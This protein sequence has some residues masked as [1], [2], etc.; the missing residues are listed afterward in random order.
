VPG[1]RR[2]PVP[3]PVKRDAVRGKFC[4]F[5]GGPAINVPAV[6]LERVDA[7]RDELPARRR[8]KVV[9]E[10][11]AGFKPPRPPFVLEIPYELLF[12]E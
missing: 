2:A 9:V 5:V 4:R 12:A 3:L 10:D 8:R 6:F 11:L 1:E 7:K